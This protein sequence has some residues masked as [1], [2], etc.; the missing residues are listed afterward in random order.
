M[1]G[2]YYTAVKALEANYI[3]T[4][5]E[6]LWIGK[7]RTSTTRMWQTAPVFSLLYIFHPISIPFS[8]ERR[9]FHFYFSL[10]ALVQGIT[11]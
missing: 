10:L 8:L 3:Q 5:Q 2:N 4:I 9:P 6:L 11:K 1:I 7:I